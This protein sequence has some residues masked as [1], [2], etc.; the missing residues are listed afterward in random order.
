MPIM[1]NSTRPLGEFIREQRKLAHLSLRELARTTRVSSAYLSQVERGLH[2]P[3]IRVLSAVADVLQVPME[4]MIAGQ[5]TAS[6]DG[7]TPGTSVR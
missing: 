5:P 7:S 3:S 4:A 1:T 6:T 2:E